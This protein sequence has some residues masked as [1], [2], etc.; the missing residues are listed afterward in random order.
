MSRFFGRNYLLE[1]TT[2]S[3]EVLRYEPPIETR[4]LVDNFPQHANAT[5]GITVFGISSW[6]RELIQLRDDAKNNYGT[7]ILKAGYGDD[8]G[9]I[10]TGRI[11]NVQVAKDGVNTCIKL[12]CSASSTEWDASSYQTWGDNT[13]YQEVIRDIAEGL[14][15]PVEFVGDFSD[16]PVLLRGRNAGGKL[17]RVLLDELKQFFGFWWLH[18]P[19]RTIIIRDGAALVCEFA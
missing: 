4:F 16:L 9:V 2:T 12:Y 7:V 18:T 11:N 10:F 3:G 8:I 15:A 1:I 13:P 14:G 6:A 5:A 19:T 17:C